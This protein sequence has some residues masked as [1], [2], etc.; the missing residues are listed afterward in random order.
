M[1]KQNKIGIFSGTFD[2]F[3]V[4][5]LE[6][7]LIAKEACGLDEV[8]VMIEK[9]PLHKT[10]VTSF[11]DRLAMVNLATSNYDSIKH[12]ENNNSNITINNTMPLIS[13][14]FHNT[15]YWQIVGSDVV[16]FLGS[17]Q[18]VSKL[19]SNMKLCVVL[20]R[21]Q[22]RLRINRQLQDLAKRYERLEYII[23]PEVWSEVSSSKIRNQIKQS[24]HS[25]DL[26]PRVMQYIKEAPIY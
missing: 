10:G 9:E 13:D 16:E 12:F 24:G 3:H 15:E 7:C 22:D 11:N 23:L 6:V 4:A 5:H 1:K 18:D 25:D 19:F 14:N 17:W 2:P 20:R 8:L 21:N 26:D